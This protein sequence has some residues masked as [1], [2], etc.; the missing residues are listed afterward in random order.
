MVTEPSAAAGVESGDRAPCHNVFMSRDA[1]T[2]VRHDHVRTGCCYGQSGQAGSG[3]YRC[4]TIRLGS[5]LRWQTSIWY[6]GGGP[7]AL[8][9]KLLGDGSGS[10]GSAE[11]PSVRERPSC[12]HQNGQHGSGGVHQSSGRVVLVFPVG[13]SE[14]A[15][16]VD[17]SGTSFDPSSTRTRQF[18]YRRGHAVQGWAQAGDTATVVPLV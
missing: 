5:P 4:I 10:S 7:E 18:E 15:A 12:S 2:L 14:A 9:Y 3:H 13:L 8:S 6:M 16:L 1:S 17:G 11:L